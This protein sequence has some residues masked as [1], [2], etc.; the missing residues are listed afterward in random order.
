MDCKDFLNFCNDCGWQ[1]KENNG[2]GIAVVFHCGES[3]VFCFP[4]GITNCQVRISAVWR[5]K[6]NTRYSFNLL[7]NGNILWPLERLEELLDFI[8]EEDKLQFMQNQSTISSAEAARLYEKKSQSRK[9]WNRQKEKLLKL[10]STERLAAVTGRVGQDVLREMLLMI[11]GGC[12]ITG[13]SQPELL[14]ASHIKPWNECDNDPRE[15]LNENN[16]LLLSA[17]LDKLFDKY[18]ISFD[19]DTGEMLVSDAIDSDTLRKL[20][21]VPKKMKLKI[22]NSE[23]A[24]F[25]RYHNRK[26]RKTQVPVK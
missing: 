26:L 20:G 21:V 16:V 10:P 5:E 3:G 9:N 17:A 2:S 24:A 11:Y 25:L 23:Q 18:F 12:Q 7:K 6:L 19:A 22:A 4:P 14:I 13:I 15:R 1:Y 8:T